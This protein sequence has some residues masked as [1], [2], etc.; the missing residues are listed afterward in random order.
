M[1]L[2]AW[3]GS[4]LVE[5]REWCAWGMVGP[6][7]FVPVAE[8]F[9]HLQLGGNKQAETCC[10]KLVRSYSLL[11][12]VWPVC[13]SVCLSV[14]F[15]PVS[16]FVSVAV[17]VVCFWMLCCQ[18]AQNLLDQ[19]HSDPGAMRLR[20]QAA[21]PDAVFRRGTGSSAR[22]EHMALLQPGLQQLGQSMRGL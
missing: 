5:T 16:L 11:V 4:C 1:Q 22:P 19:A 13:L 20:L 15:L 8:G 10:Q 7:C 9:H 6:H 12:I 14:C 18:V 3:C 17:D 21:V 2:H